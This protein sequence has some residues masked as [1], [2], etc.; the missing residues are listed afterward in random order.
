M[1]G[2]ND[3]AQAVYNNAEAHG[4]HETNPDWGNRLLLIVSEIKE[5]QDELRNGRFPGERYYSQDGKPEGVPSELADVI[6]RTLDLMV[7]MGIDNIE[8]VVSEKIIYNQ[9]RPYKHGK[10]F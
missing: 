8:D 1:P 4:F 2:L 3:L 10:E 5:A 6:I 7:E 9:S